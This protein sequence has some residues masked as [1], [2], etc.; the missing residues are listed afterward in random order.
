MRQELREIAAKSFNVQLS[1][2]DHAPDREVPHV[3]V[4]ALANALEEAFKAGTQHAPGGEDDQQGAEMRGVIARLEDLHAEFD[5][6]WTIE[7]ESHNQGDGT[8]HFTHVVTHRTRMGE[9]LRML[10]ARHATPALAELM[11]LSHNNL[12]K[13]LRLA[14]LGLDRR[15]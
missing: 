2:A 3:T 10:I 13:L 11:T 4:A 14:R 1:A 12:P 7:N 8:T 5:E 6:T 15:G 9:E